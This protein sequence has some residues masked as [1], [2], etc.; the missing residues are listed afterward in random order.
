[1]THLIICI[2]ISFVSPTFNPSP[3]LLRRPIQARSF[4]TVQSKPVP[5]SPFDPSPF[6]CPPVH[7]DVSQ[8]FYSN[9]TFVVHPTEPRTLP[10]ALA[11]TVTLTTRNVVKTIGKRAPEVMIV[12]GIK[13]RSGLIVS[14]ETSLGPMTRSAIHRR[15]INQTM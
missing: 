8:I 9:Q 1:M 6:I 3:F 2:N 7:K 11:L 14:I 10:A 15:W 5:S 4:A 13:P 12:R